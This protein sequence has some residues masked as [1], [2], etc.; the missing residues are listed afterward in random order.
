MEEIKACKNCRYWERFAVSLECKE[1]L[2]TCT[3]IK[4]YDDDPDEDYPRLAITA[5]D[6]YCAYFEQKTGE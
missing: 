3:K 1:D 2:D 4:I 6:F 5:P